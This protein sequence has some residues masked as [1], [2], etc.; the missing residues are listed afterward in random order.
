MELRSLGPGVELLV[1]PAVKFKTV[2]LRI[3]LRSDLDEH[4]TARNVI[5]AVLGRGTRSYPNLQALNAKLDSL[6]GAAFVNDVN[7]VGDWHVHVF[8]MSLVSGR[9]VPQGDSLLSEGAGLLKEILLD[10]VR[11]NG[12][13]VPSVVDGEKENLRRALENQ[14][15]DKARYALLRH[16][17]LMFKGEPYGRNVLGRIEDLGGLTPELLWEKYRTWVG[18]AP[19]TVLVGGDVEAGRLEDLFAG[20]AEGRA[21]AQP[22][23]ERTELPP[24][25]EVKEFTEEMDVQQGKLCIGYRH[26]AVI[27]DP[28]LA[29]V[30][31]MTGLLGGFPHAKLFQQVRERESLAYAVSA[32]Y[33]E[34]KGVLVVTAGIDPGSYARVK[35]LVFESVDQ[36][37]RGKFSREDLEATKAGMVRRL[38]AVEDNLAAYLAEVY[39]H[40]LFGEEFSPAGAIRRIRE[41]QA[42]EVCAAARSLALDTIYF[43]RSPS[44]RGDGGSGNMQAGRKDNE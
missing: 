4:I 39:V 7:K 31:V 17:E 23:K 22:P 44:G 24:P 12:S 21:E 6:Y 43:L 20:L 14:I 36:I 15:S 32:F 38:Q 26:G 33:D 8:A 37:G 13:F 3:H 2:V 16:T 41:V 18:R 42:E 25:G 19:I 28:S 11:L 1:V 27:G 35:E 5:A 34:T 10:P 9:Y 40:R 30:Q 29:A